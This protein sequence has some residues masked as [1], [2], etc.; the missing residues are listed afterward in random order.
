MVYEEENI[1]K[2]HKGNLASKYT[3]L[4]RF[5]SVLRATYLSRDV[6]LWEFLIFFFFNALYKN[7]LLLLLPQAKKKH[8]PTYFKYRGHQFLVYNTES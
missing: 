8:F 5:L 6:Y 3:L 2:S 7:L 4:K 1:T